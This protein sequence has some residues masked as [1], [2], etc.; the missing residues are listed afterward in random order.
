MKLVFSGAQRG[1]TGSCHLLKTKDADSNELQLLFDCGMFQ[2]QQ[3]CGTKNQEEFGFDPKEIDAVFITHPHAD[4]IGRLPRLVR[5]GFE[6]K[7]YM[8]TPCLALARIVLEDAHHIMKEDAQK[9]GS[10]VLY[11]IEDLIETFQQAEGVGY[12][13]EV[14][15]GNGVKVMFHDAGHVL[16]SSYISVDAEGKRVV[17]S[18]DIGNDNVPILPDT[19][20]ISHADVVVSESTYGSRKHED[21][22]SRQRVLKECIESTIKTKS[23]L[24][25][26]AFS[27][28]RT[29]ELLYE[30][31]LLLKDMDTKIPIFL[32][33]PMAIKATQV[34]RDFSEYL[35]FDADILKEDDRDFFSFPNLVITSSTQ[36][37]KKINDT[38]TPKII[39]AGS[40]MMSGGRIMHHLIRY[41]GD[42]KNIVLVIGYQAHGTTGRKIYEG[43]NRVKIFNEDVTVNARVKS[44]GSFSAHGDADKILRWLKPK[45][46]NIP[47][48]FLVHGDP[49]DKEVFATELRH[50][51]KTEVIIPEYK[52]EHEI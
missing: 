5:E 38:P 11:E 23:V 48:V 16:G 2:G 45:E 25:I 43:A 31:N 22:E 17:F 20:P 8:T 44:I 46:G 37:S 14:Q 47:K 3:L 29:Q 36:D 33:S 28:E 24:M 1:V 39:I 34:Y 9:C 52:S 30:I 10:S 4:H 50:K 7:I 41:L 6:G 42:K 21:I 27:I 26:P 49:E 18:G 32:D 12:H 40:G 13:Q 51:L 19:E 35:K 15:I